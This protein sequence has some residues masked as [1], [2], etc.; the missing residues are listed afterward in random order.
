[1][2]TTPSPV[3]E[4]KTNQ[5]ESLDG[6]RP[7]VK[8]GRINTPLVCQFSDREE[9]HCSAKVLPESRLISVGGTERPRHLKRR[10]Q[11]GW[12]NEH[13]WRSPG[14]PSY[15][16]TNSSTIL[17]AHRIKTRMEQRDS[18][19][20]ILPVSKMNKLGRQLSVLQIFM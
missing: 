9:V 2:R 18:I 5:T 11:L 13:R 1:M 20:P 3:A 15:L 4:M 7:A 6:A 16:P 12:Q 19:L 14:Q 10:R 8:F 17:S